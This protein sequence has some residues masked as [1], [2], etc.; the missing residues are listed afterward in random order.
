MESSEQSDVGEERSHSGR[1]QEEKAAG[2]RKRD[3]GLDIIFLGKMKWTSKQ[4][5]SST[6]LSVAG[7][8]V[9]TLL[10]VHHEL[11]AEIEEKQQLTGLRRGMT[12]PQ[13]PWARFPCTLQKYR[14]MTE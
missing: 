4:S 3:T 6:L 14:S 2:G 7:D 1:V 13:S 5:P 12:E 8:S 10:P 11:G 9:R